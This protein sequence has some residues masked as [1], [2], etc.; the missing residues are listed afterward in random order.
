[1][2]E[3]I[4]MEESNNSNR[5]QTR[6]SS[7][8]TRSAS[9]VMAEEEV[10]SPVSSVGEAAMSTTLNEGRVTRSQSVESSGYETADSRKRKRK[11]KNSSN[12]K[13]ADSYQ[14]SSHTMKSV[15]N[16]LPAL[17]TAPVS[18]STPKG[19][20]GEDMERETR[21]TTQRISK[22]ARDAKK[23]QRDIIIRER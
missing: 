15:N 12:K 11:A 23:A 22:E 2:E 3:S 18:M 19:S 21:N 5:I 14:P 7:R 6:R 20:S 13:R 4:V 10:G 16:S 8:S 17:S 9:P 1:M